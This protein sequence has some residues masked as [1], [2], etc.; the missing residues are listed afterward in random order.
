MREV[1]LERVV[2]AGRLDDDVVDGA[3][4][5]LADEADATVARR[6]DLR[7]TDLAPRRQHPL[8]PSLRSA[9]RMLR[10]LPSELRIEPTLGRRRG[11][12]R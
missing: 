6:R 10:S 8:I 7:Q 5:A 12:A 3:L 9:G 2:L 1:P 11:G 4:A